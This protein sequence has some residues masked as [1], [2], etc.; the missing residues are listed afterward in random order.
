V[1]EIHVEPPIRGWAGYP[2]GFVAAVAVTTVAVAA[3]GTAHPLWTLVALA[4]TASAIAVVATLR[5]ALATGALCWAL[6]AGFVIGRFGELTLNADAVRA[7]VVVAAVVVLGFGIAHVVR[8]ARR[9]AAARVV[10]IQVRRSTPA[11]PVLRST[12]TG[13]AS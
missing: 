10:P 3:G 12:G 11:I 4:G 5:A 1:H 6:Q 8:V 13:H 2:L 9:S 7:A